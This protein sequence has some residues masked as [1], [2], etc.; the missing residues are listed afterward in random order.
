MLRPGER[1][2]DWIVEAR[3]GEGEHGAIFLARHGLNLNLRGALKVARPPDYEKARNNFIAEIEP[4]LML[5]H[6][7]L[8]HVM[9]WGEDPER[10][11]LWMTTELVRGRSLEERL[12]EGPFELE[13]LGFVFG[14]L[15]GALALIHSHGASHGDLRPSDVL[16][17]EGRHIRITGFGTVFRENHQGQL[18]AESLA[19]VGPEYF[20]D[21]ESCSPVSADIYALGLILH[22]AIT[23]K[24]VFPVD[25]ALKPAPQMARIMG[26]KMRLGAL[27]PG[28]DVPLPLRR[29][30]LQCT[31]PD[32]EAR[33]PDLSGFL[34]ALSM[35]TRERE[36]MGSI[37][38]VTP[39]PRP[40][41][42]PAPPT[43][44]PP[45]AEGGRG[46]DSPTVKLESSVLRKQERATP[47]PFAPP[48]WG[49]RAH[50]VP[51]PMAGLVRTPGPP[52]PPAP[53]Q[54][55]GLEVLQREPAAPAPPVAEESLFDEPEAVEPPPV[56]ERLVPEPPL[57]VEAAVPAV[58]P[59]E[60]VEEAVLV[61]PEAEVGAHDEWSEDVGTAA[62]APVETDPAS[63]RRERER[64]RRAFVPPPPVPDPSFVAPASQ[65]AGAPAP[66]EVEPVTEPVAA[67]EPAS[68]E[69]AADLVPPPPVVEPD[70]VVEPEPQPEPQPVRPSVLN[71]V[72][73]AP[74]LIDPVPTPM[75]PV[76]A[77]APTRP[78]APDEVPTSRF[79]PQESPAIAP[80]P[81]P[82][83]SAAVTTPFEPMP[84]TPDVPDIEAPSAPTLRALEADPAVEAEPEPDA[85]PAVVDPGSHQTHVPLEEP[86][87]AELHD[88]EDW[89]W[90]EQVEEHDAP[91]E[92][93]IDAFSRPIDDLYADDLAPSAS[94]I[95]AD[96]FGD[97]GE[98]FALL[99]WAL[100]IV[101]VI[102]ILVVA[103]LWWDRGQTDVAEPPAEPPA[104]EVAELPSP[105]PVEPPPIEQEPEP[106]VTAEE[107][108]LEDV[109]AEEQ[110]VEAE[111]APAPLE[112][113]SARGTSPRAAPTS[114]PSSSR[115]PSPSPS[116]RPQPVS[117]P[118]PA[119]AVAMVEP[120]PEPAQPAASEKG[121]MDY[122]RDGW[123]A[124][125]SGNLVGAQGAFM[126]ALSK[127][128]G[129][130]MAHYGL[131]QVAERARDY[132]SAAYHYGRALSALG[133]NPT[134][135]GELEAAI[136]RVNSKAGAAAA[137]VPAPAAAPAASTDS[138]D[139]VEVS[140]KKRDPLEESFRDEI[141][142]MEESD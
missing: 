87:P 34:T 15:A 137:P 63:M 122:L 127:D 98:G 70:I 136:R 9:G 66:D 129:N 72:P 126:G 94:D 71:I 62:P 8:I 67:D 49:P 54:A 111:P 73:P 51:A 139:S 128:S 53:E 79:S 13:E 24:R 97:H 7:A 89:S 32:P 103:F 28:D 2:G 116:P 40:D 38:S 56:A 81:E 77:E 101:A 16:L 125:D 5:R 112:T 114:A 131:G 35:A 42:D 107:L 84:V 11:L 50:R 21:P 19:Y 18:D 110:P 41:P 88:D 59:D 3:L 140:R 31:D 95:A 27:D 1:I 115:P 124:L 60:E 121:V 134:M 45:V 141:W 74:R 92:E 69:P 138:E 17:A 64:Q 78:V 80:A 55:G 83:E 4:L 22:E 93:R 12:E 44:P 142:D 123:S 26:M 6:E 90:H 68:P 133:G 85:T 36:E 10:N 91:T 48:G 119:P 109:V 57:V 25:P 135:K 29:I 23:G 37:T 117:V 46:T 30:V 100:P 58:A 39:V 102:A 104:G 47:F 132:R 86:P 52:G 108:G 130:G 43:E 118:E 14:R 75:A 105:P 82:A 96:V 61:E 65:P 76:E 113:S 20:D 99:K 33:P 106:S 120:E